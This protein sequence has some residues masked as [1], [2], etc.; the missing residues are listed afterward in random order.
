MQRATLIRPA[1]WPQWTLSENWGGGFAPFLG[2][3]LDPHLIQSRLGLGL[4]Y[5]K[6]YLNPSSHLATTDMG[7]N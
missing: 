7:Q 2:R 4:P 6:W 5:T 1:V 3:E